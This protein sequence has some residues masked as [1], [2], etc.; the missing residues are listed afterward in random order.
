MNAIKDYLHNNREYLLETLAPYADT[1]ELLL[2][3]MSGV[4]YDD[5]NEQYISKTKSIITEEISR[6]TGEPCDIILE[7]LEDIDYKTYIGLT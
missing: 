4:F 7:V 1:R 2:K 5:I 6:Q 3:T